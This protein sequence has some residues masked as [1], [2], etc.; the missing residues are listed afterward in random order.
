MVIVSSECRIEDIGT[1]YT[2]S[3]EKL[4]DYDIV[5]SDRE[6]PGMVKKQDRRNK[7]L[8]RKQLNAKVIGFVVP[9]KFNGLKTG[10]SGYMLY[11]INIEKDW[12]FYDH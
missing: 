4:N 12:G 5:E 1:I 2:A 10:K 11:K 6:N 3:K 7:E 8:S 9:D